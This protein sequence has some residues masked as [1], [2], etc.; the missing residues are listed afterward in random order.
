[1]SNSSCHHIKFWRV[2]QMGVDIIRFAY[3]S[4]PLEGRGTGSNLQ[5]GFEF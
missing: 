5:L 2:Q 1:M 4:D 3:D